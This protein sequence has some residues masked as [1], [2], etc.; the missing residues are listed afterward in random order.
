MNIKQ[1][2]RRLVK[3]LLATSGYTLTKIDPARPTMARA[4]Q[5]IRA[6][7][8]PIHTV[9]DIGASDGQWSRA[10]MPYYPQA[11]YLL[12]EAQP[13]HE[14]AL[15]A[16]C[17]EHANARYVL[18]AAGSEA[19]ELYFDASHPLG[20]Q[21]AYTPFPAHNIVVPVT[22]VDLEVQK[23][24]LPGPFLLKLD[25]HGF[26]MP[27]LRGA[28][29]TLA[30][31]E[32]IVIECYNFAIAPECLLFYEMAAHLTDLGF[33][34]ADVVDVMYRPHDNLLWQM[35]MVFIRAERPE[36]AHLNYD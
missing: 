1:H 21:A 9:I 30:Q 25:T 26:E 27:I 2:A 11:Q 20:G 32:V 22:A 18:A 12:I 4:M 23:H 28:Q 24:R 19:G 35:D 29:A 16:F 36:F 10:L 34:C 33:R 15:Q 31:T 14:K 3:R 5:A 13:V 6:R 7:Q 8:H 17:L